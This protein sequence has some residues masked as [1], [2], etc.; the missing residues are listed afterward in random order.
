M[1][2]LPALLLIPAFALIGAA[3]QQREWLGAIVGGLIGLFF[4]LLVMGLL[5]RQILNW[6]FPRSHNQ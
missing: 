3:N 4:A 2:R 1:N 6:M 5:P